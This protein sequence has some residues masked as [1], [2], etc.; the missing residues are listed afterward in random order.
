L[1]TD[2]TDVPWGEETDLVVVE[3]TDLGMR[4]ESEGAGMT[5]A[6]RATAP[7]PANVARL[8]PG[9]AVRATL[10]G[11][12]ET[13]VRIRDAAGT[14]L[15][16]GGDPD[17]VPAEVLPRLAMW[18][19]GADDCRPERDDDGRCFT[20]EP[21][22]VSVTA[23]DGTMELARDEPA[24]ISIDGRRYR[25]WDLG[26]FVAVAHDCSL[27]DGASVHAFVAPDCPTDLEGAR[28]P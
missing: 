27:E 2:A 22:T 5:L 23:D 24:R 21:L 26:S 9:A 28:C 19:T 25:A 13:Y 18:R 17:G 8:Q 11:T 14:L 20:L 4:L 15:W 7:L 3:S 16:E 1:S 10:S 6:I 12:F